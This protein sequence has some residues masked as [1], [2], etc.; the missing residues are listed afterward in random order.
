MPHHVILLSIIIDALQKLSAY[1]LSGDWVES[2]RNAHEQN[3]QKVGFVIGI[4]F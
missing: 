1:R 4:K 2:L 3:Q